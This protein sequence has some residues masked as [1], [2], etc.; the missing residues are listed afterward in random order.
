MKHEVRVQATGQAEALEPVSSN[1]RYLAFAMAWP[2]RMTLIEGCGFFGLA[3][4][5]RERLETP[6]GR[7][8]VSK[9]SKVIVSRSS[10]FANTMFRE[11]LVDVPGKRM[12]ERLTEAGATTSRGQPLYKS[13]SSSQGRDDHMKS[14]HLLAASAATKVTR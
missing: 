1:S 8:P 2:V 10:G 5:P 7:N 11:R 9:T 12:D 4:L 6:I 14:S 13:G 3:E